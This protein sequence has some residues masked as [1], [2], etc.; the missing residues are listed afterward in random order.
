MSGIGYRQVCQLLAGELELEEAV[1]SI[2][3]QTHRLA[4]MQHT[5]FR[6][7]DA[8]IDWIDVSTGDPLATSLRVLES[9]LKLA[10]GDKQ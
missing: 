4:R 5:W 9:K 8:R 2:K 6:A 7:D 3:T 1:R 10:E